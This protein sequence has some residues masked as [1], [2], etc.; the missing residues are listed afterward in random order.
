MK[1]LTYGVLSSLLILATA[2]PS[3]ATTPAPTIAQANSA[4]IDQM[5]QEQ[6]VLTGE[7]QTMM[8]QM[9]MMMAEMKA[10]TSIPEGQTPTTTDLYK[11]QQI[12]IAQVET[13]TNR[14]KLD[15]IL[16][17]GK[18]TATV[19]DVY[20]QQMA[21]AADLKAMM[22]EMKTML[23]AYRGRAGAYRR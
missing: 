16:S 15:T 10:L 18:R 17:P 23:E 6:R 8:A 20:Q 5:F 3:G 22:A 21:M 9:K 2:I 1:K 13:L 12:L 11:Q 7:L 19:Q 14:T 4:S